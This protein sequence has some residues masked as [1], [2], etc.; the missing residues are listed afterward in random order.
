MD[1]AFAL[2]EGKRGAIARSTEVAHHIK[3]HSEEF[4]LLLSLLSRENEVCVSHAAHALQT[5]GK[6]SP[7]LVTG[8]SQHIC[9]ALVEQ[10]QWELTEAFSKLLPILHISEAEAERACSVL[11]TRFC[12]EKGSLARTW[13]LQALVDMAEKYPQ[14]QQ[15]A[16]DA[17]QAALETGSKAMQARA[18]KL[19]L[20]KR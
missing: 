18:R 14:H 13:A 4:E 19:L 10:N 3:D 20:R 17:L 9:E 7:E 11:Y 12:D 2:G 1:I 15:K 8:G 16:E 5:L 6:I